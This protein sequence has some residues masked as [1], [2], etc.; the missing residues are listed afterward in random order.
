VDRMAQSVSMPG[1]DGEASLRPA[2][3]AYSSSH[4]RGAVAGLVPQISAGGRGTA[5]CQPCACITGDDCGCCGY[6]GLEIFLAT[7]R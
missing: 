6:E 7:G 1:F 3:R 5:S 4:G 2:S